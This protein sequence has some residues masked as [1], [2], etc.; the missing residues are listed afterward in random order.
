[1]KRFLIAAALALAPTTVLAA[2]ATGSWSFNV[3][4]DSVGE[5]F[6][7]TCA[8]KQ[9][10]AGDVTGSCGGLANE[11]A[12]V[13]G[14]TRIGT[15]G[16]PVI[17]FGYDTDYSGTGVHLEYIAEPQPDGSLAGSVFVKGVSGTF[18]AVRK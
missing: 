16:K 15:D 7:T 12:E 8:L 14:K 18:T 6:V 3:V 1:M 5:K 11:Q 4:F 9:S 10:P 17:D 2:D 13:S